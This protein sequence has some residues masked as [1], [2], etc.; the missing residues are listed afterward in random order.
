[1][2]ETTTQSSVHFGIQVL[3]T[4][5]I[6]RYTARKKKSISV[7]EAVLAAS[8]TDRAVYN[9]HNQLR[10]HSSPVEKGLST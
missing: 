7:S 6:K 5:P 4:Q 2:T 1:L 3:G 9:K 10:T 8:L